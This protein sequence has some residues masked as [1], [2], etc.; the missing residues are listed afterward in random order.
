M[1]IQ[2]GSFTYTGDLITIP[3]VKVFKDSS[4]LKVYYSQ[5]S[6]DEIRSSPGK[7]ILEQNYPNPFNPTTTIRYSIPKEELVSLK[8]SNSIG[9]EVAVLV[10]ENKPAGNYEVDFNASGFSSG[11]YFYRL[12]AGEFYQI[13]KMVLIK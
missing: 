1:T 6:I 8:I 9:Q 3:G 13:K 10:Y 5:T 7:F 4:C 12:E 2:N 11:V